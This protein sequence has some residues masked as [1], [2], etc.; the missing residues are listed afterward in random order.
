MVYQH[1]FPL[2]AF[3]Y[4]SPEVQY[5]L[6]AGRMERSPAPGPKLVFR[7]RDLGLHLAA[8]TLCLCYCLTSRKVDGQKE[9][10]KDLARHT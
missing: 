10:S 7:C 8:A 9:G 3:E 6:A 4:L 2:A 1:M 5:T